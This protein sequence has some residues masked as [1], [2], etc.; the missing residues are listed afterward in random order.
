MPLFFHSKVIQVSVGEPETSVSICT[1]TT[2][3]R[4]EIKHCLCVIFCESFHARTSAPPTLAEKSS[5]AGNSRNSPNKSAV[6]TYF[7]LPPLRRSS[8]EKP[9]LMIRP[10]PAPPL[11]SAALCHKHTLLR[12]RS[13]FPHTAFAS[14]KECQAAR[15]PRWLLY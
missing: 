11:T 9:F 13:S 14:P 10:V 1:R 8:A 5:G 2:C 15:L 3:Y 12:G 4:S 7:T 6:T